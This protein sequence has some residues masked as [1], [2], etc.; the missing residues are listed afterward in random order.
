M[1]SM[2]P[3][4]GPVS[5]WGLSEREIGVRFLFRRAGSLG[6]L[7]RCD[8]S[9]P[10]GCGSLR[11]PGSSPAGAGPKFFPV[12]PATLLAWHRKLAGRMCFGILIVGCPATACLRVPCD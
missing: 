8:T 9:R 4:G 11:W 3:S 12:T 7:A 6:T 5:P 10:A 1:T 2:D